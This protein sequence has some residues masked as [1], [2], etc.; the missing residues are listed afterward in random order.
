MARR[1]QAAPNVAQVGRPFITAVVRAL[2]FMIVD[3]YR[4][5]GLISSG[6]FMFCSLSNQLE[7][8]QILAA[9]S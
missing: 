9:S 3:K 4:Y 1:T 6:M 7:Q 8:F 5:S 2:V